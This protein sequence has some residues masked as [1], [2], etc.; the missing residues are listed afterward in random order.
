MGLPYS[1][2]FFAFSISSF[3]W[4]LPFFLISKNQEKGKKNGLRQKIYPV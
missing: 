3:E 1:Q 4:W 2:S